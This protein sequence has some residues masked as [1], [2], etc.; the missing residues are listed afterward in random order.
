MLFVSAHSL[1]CA[2]QERLWPI[3]AAKRIS[4]SFGEPRT[5]RF[6]YGMDFKSDG[7]T[8]KKI[9]AIGDGYVSRVRT[10]PYGY[11]KALYI[12][13]DSGEL[14]VYGHLSAFRD[15]IEERLFH[16]RI[17]AKTYDVQLWPE[18]NT[19]RV[20]KGEVIGRSGDSGSWGAPHLHMEIR[21]PG[22][23]SLNLLKQGYDVRDTIPP[24]ITSVVLIPLD[25]FSLVDGQPFERWI[26]VDGSEI[27]PVCL[28]GRIGAA[29]S[30]RDRAN[31]SSNHLGVYDISLAADSTTVFSKRY[32]SL[33]Y[34]EMSYD[35]LDYL[36]GEYYGG[37]G[38]L[39]ALFK[40][41][42]NQLHFYEGDGILAN[43]NPDS[44]SSHSIVIT[45]GDFPGNRTDVSI[46]VIYGT[47]PKFL[48][49]GLDT[50]EE[51][52]IVGRTPVGDLARLDILSLSGNGDSEIVRSYPVDGDFCDVIIDASELPPAY[53]AVLVSRDS[54]KT[55]A[56]LLAAV[57]TGSIAEEQ[58]GK[59]A[60]T[61]TLRHD[62]V[63]V[64]ITANEPLA[65]VPILSSNLQRGSGG[66][67]VCP[68]A[69]SD[70]RWAAA[71]PLS[72]PGNHHLNLSVFAYDRTGNRITADTKMDVT[73]FDMK[74][75]VPCVSNDSL[76]QAAAT[77]ETFFRQAPVTLT[78]EETA[79]DKELVPLSTGYRI[80]LGD[81]V[82]RDAI[83]VCLA[84]G[85]NVPS[86]AALYF[87]NGN[88]NNGYNGNSHRW[89]FLS[90]DRAD[91][92]FTGGIDKPGCF[93]V[94]D[95]TTAPY[96][97]P[98]SPKPGGTIRNRRPVLK[99][100]VSDEGAGL[101]GSDST[102]MT[103]NGIPVYGEYNPKAHTVSYRIRDGLRPG[104]HTAEV[105]A[106]DQAGNTR[107]RQWSF[108]IE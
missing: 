64:T 75:P 19:F 47:P 10:S 88:G 16:R 34:N 48:Y 91:S 29:V 9:Y 8:G 49:C 42:G 98:L 79:A 104:K 77:E 63:I 58:S 14:V 26:P 74:E 18:P 87:H 28:T 4:S 5:G 1:R 106:A 2:E 55:A 84:A 61:T 81:P 100:Y 85:D 67:V 97:R 94:F 6:H 23:V 33:S 31:G 50:T 17:Q 105:T 39:S 20:K 60:V 52:R 89:N 25:R 102:V 96:I 92:V 68:A 73:V 95:D 107:S 66:V 27:Q 15:D 90:G 43:G 57:D 62:R 76:F 12:T 99:V 7:V 45:A 3:D 13:L 41:E 40:K 37:S 71:V 93:A 69:L 78:P 53:K 103:I 32:D 36:P 56:S 24:R 11:G 59:L 82:L 51:I 21:S 86:T 83:N 80:N 101:Q 30:V 35:R 65:S 72:T 108:T 22:D 70:T 46:P 54:L 44:T 38:K